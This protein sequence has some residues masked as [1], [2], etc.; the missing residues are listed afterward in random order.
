MENETQLL[1]DLEDYDKI[2][3]EENPFITGK[4]RGTRHTLY[5]DCGVWVLVSGGFYFPY[6]PDPD[7]YVMIHDYIKGNMPDSAFLEYV[8][9]PT[10]GSFEDY[11][12]YHI[13]RAPG[14]F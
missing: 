6:Y 13:T 5:L 10:M 8:V 3:S 12:E 14:D 11:L 2:Y 4:M 9:E 1:F 7:K